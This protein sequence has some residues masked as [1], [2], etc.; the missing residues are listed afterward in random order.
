MYTVL[1]HIWFLHKYIVD[2]RA[3]HHV[4][5]SRACHHVIM[6]SCNICNEWTELRRNSMKRPPVLPAGGAGLSLTANCWP[7]HGGAAFTRRHRHSRHNSLLTMATARA[8]VW[9]AFWLLWTKNLS[10]LTTSNAYLA[11]SIDAHDGI[12][13]SCSCWWL[14]TEN[15]INVRFT[16]HIDIG[17]YCP[18]YTG[19]AWRCAWRLVT[20]PRPGPPLVHRPVVPAPIGWAGASSEQTQHGLSRVAALRKS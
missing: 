1:L 17:K 10:L 11:L 6:S 9:W 19:S 3:C 18:M 12:G 15:K 13:C 2:R 20:W 14:S 16:N 5:M 4:I 8:G 7:A